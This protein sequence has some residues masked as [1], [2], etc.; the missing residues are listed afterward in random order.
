MERRHEDMRD[1]SARS[2]R[3]AEL[4]TI[5]IITDSC[6]DLPPDE[7]IREKI[8]LVPIRVIFGNDSYLD[9]ITITDDDFYRL[10]SAAPVHPKTSQNGAGGLPRG[11]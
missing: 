10:L 6:C 11:L 8:R 1:Q 4:Q 7:I 3:N 2:H 5:A 9:K